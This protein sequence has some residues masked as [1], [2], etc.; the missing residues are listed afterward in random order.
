MITFDDF[1]KVE[2]R[3]GE[4]KEAEKVE[5]SDKLLKLNVS[6]GE[7]DVRQVVSGIAKYFDTK[8]IIGTKALF[9][10]NL[11]SRSIMGLESQAMICASGE[12]ETFSLAIPAG[13]A[14]PGDL[15]H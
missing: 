13:N 2:I 12:G 8:D 6:F 5:G 9:V 11:E 4:I 7:N 1:K 15:I 14:K 3:V 10:T